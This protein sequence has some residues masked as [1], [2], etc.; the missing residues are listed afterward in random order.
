[1]AK[2]SAAT[3][4]V[5]RQIKRIMLDPFNGVLALFFLILAIVLPDATPAAD[6][7]LNVLHYAT[8]SLLCSL[9]AFFAWRWLRAV[10]ARATRDEVEEEVANLRTTT[11]A[12]DA[13]AKTPGPTP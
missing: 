13:S 4:R 7:K 12:Q 10:V 3:Q 11:F 8:L 1:M 5:P 6:G 2:K 9:S